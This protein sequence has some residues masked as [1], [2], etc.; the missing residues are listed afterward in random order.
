MS[1]FVR[2]VLKYKKDD[3]AWGDIARDVAAD[4]EIKRTWNWEAFKKHVEDKACASAWAVMEEM[5]E[6]YTRRGYPPL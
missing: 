2:F 4:S 1:S 6:A 5:K 3:S